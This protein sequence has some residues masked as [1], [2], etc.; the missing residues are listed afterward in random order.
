MG[1]GQVL[2]LE[3]LRF[4]EHPCLDPD[5]NKVSIEQNLKNL[6]HKDEISLVVSAVY[7]INKLPQHYMSKMHLDFVNFRCVR[8]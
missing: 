2:I 8:S 5:L 3:Y 1:L 4:D 7:Y 6:G